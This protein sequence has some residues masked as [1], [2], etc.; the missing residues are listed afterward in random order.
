V[1]VGK[2]WRL[3]RDGGLRSGIRREV[4]VKN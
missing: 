1:E 2:R 3:A 4:I